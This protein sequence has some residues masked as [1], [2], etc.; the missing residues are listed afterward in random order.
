MS[1]DSFEKKTKQ[2]ENQNQTCICDSNVNISLKA[3]YD[4]ILYDTFEITEGDYFKFTLH[5]YVLPSS[6]L[7]CKYIFFPIINTFYLNAVLAE[8]R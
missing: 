3:S 6:K 1:V 2:H 5:F 4:V 8:F 7:C